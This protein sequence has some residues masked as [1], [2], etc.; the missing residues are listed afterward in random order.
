MPAP[1]PL[2]CRAVVRLPAKGAGTSPT[3]ALLPKLTELRRN[4]REIRQWRQ[5]P[6]PILDLRMSL[7]LVRAHAMR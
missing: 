4:W 7:A 1:A 2:R 5:N 3:N 6:D